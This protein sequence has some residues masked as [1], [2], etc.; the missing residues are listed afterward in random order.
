VVITGLGA[1][2]PIGLN[3]DEYWQALIAGKN[4]I[5]PITL[6]DPT[7]F[8]VKIAAEVKGFDAEKYLPLKRVDRTSRVTHLGMVAARMAIESAKLNLDAENPSDIGVV[9]ATS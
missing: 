9:I 8:P 1:L 3:V 2:T 4:G 7:L 6:F 5:G